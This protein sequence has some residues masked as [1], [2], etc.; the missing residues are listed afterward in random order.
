MLDL[1]FTEEA[2][3]IKLTSCQVEHF[4]SHHKLVFGLLNIKKPP[5][6]KKIL[7]VCE[8]KHITIE[9]FK[10]DFNEDAIDLTSPADTVLYQF[11]NKLHKALDA[12]APLKGISSCCPPE[13]TLV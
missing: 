4:L 11:N 7:S 3:S 5:T 13:T 8:L 9:S 12:T 6:E 10:A 2:T 1:I